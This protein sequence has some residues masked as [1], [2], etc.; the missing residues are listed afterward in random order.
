MKFRKLQQLNDEDQWEDH[1]Y[2][3]EREDGQALFRYNNLVWGQ[4]GARF[5]VKLREAKTKLEEVHQIIPATKRLRWLEVEEMDGDPE[6]IQAYLDKVCE[7]PWL[8]PVPL[9]KPIVA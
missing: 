3:F 7:M 6:E 5:N 4:M 1:G 9:K 8:Q 2:A